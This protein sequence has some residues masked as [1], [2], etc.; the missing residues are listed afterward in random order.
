MTITKKL[1]PKLFLTA[2]I[3]IIM[4][5]IHQL[6]AME[7]KSAT[8]SDK[9]SLEADFQ[10]Y[11]VLSILKIDHPCYLPPELVQIIA[12]NT[13]KVI[14]K[15]CHEKYGD[16]LSNPESLV[17]FIEERCNKSMN[18]IS[19]ANIVKRCLRH[20][21]TSLDKIK[22]SYGHTVFHQITFQ[23]LHFVDNILARVEWIK[24][25]C[26][27]AGSEAWNLICMKN[28][29]YKETPLH[30]N[31]ELFSYT[32]IIKELFSAAPNAQAVW[33]LIIAPDKYNATPLNIATRNNHPKTIKLLESYRPKKTIKAKLKRLFT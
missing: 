10:A 25:L 1:T 23:D 12:I 32:E 15:E 19:T 14:D 30:C 22:D 26:L 6:N 21:G 4:T 24:I 20:S 3:M 18:H 9:V 8:T 5:G 13:S 27:V 28:Y 7:R 29:D 31:C 16:C 17:S 2:F 11:L 33:D